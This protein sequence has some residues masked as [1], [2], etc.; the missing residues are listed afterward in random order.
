MVTPREKNRV[1]VA[2]RS[3]TPYLDEN[4]SEAVGADDA[5]ESGVLLHGFCRSIPQLRDDPYRT[6]EEV[7]NML[8]KAREC[9][10]DSEGTK[11]YNLRHMGSGAKLSIMHIS[12]ALFP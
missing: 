7:Q 5:S 10:R 1:A 9:K 4:P 12:N 6:I 11:V 8:A 3:S 2:S